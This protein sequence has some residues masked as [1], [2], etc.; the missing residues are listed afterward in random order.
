[1]KGWH[2]VG[3]IPSPAGGSVETD[4]P[5]EQ[6]NLGLVEKILG[7]MCNLVAHLTR[8]TSVIVAQR[9]PV[10][11]KI[12][13]RGKTGTLLTEVDMSFVIPSL[14]PET[15]PIILCRDVQLDPQLCQH[16]LCRLMPHMRSLMVFLVPGLPLEKR[17]VLKIVNPRKAAFS[18][19]DL[20]HV[21]T[22]LSVIISDLLRLDESN[23]RAPAEA[24]GIKNLLANYER[25]LSHS[26]ATSHPQLGNELGAVSSFL[27]ETLIHKRVLHSRNG[28]D[29]VSLRSWRSAIKKYQIAAL[30]A[31]KLDPPK[32]FAERIADE[33]ARSVEQVHGAAVIKAVVPVPPGSSGK[34][35]SLSTMLAEEVAKN[36]GAQY[37]NALEPLSPPRNGKSSP[38]KSASLSGYRLKTPVKGPVLI[39]DDV[40][41]SGRHIELAIGACKLL[42]TPVYA[43]VWLGK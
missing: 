19:G 17:A 24:D 2:E 12:K 35:T 1:M 13:V 40:A 18:D 27:C 31:L 14:N 11:Q 9:D 36:L 7:E 16:P 41:S 15:M 3:S 6:P 37:V 22:D 4:N 21:L 32:E 10:S 43:A 33:L 29:Y 39:V 8:A 23:G 26:V 25:R 38:H 28:L 5:F 30:Q 42:E 34:T 20:I